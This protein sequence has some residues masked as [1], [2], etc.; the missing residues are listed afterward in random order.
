MIEVPSIM[1]IIDHLKDHCSFISVG[2]NDLIQYILAVD[3]LNEKVAFMY[4]PGHPAVLRTLDHIIQSCHQHGLEINV[5]GEMAGDILYAPLL[6]GMGVHNL[7]LNPG[8]Y[9]EIKYLMRSVT[10]VELKALVRE[11][12]ENKS[13]VDTAKK[14]KKFY[15]EKLHSIL[16]KKKVR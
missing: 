10:S 3:R 11:V 12:L 16:A 4:N 9:T 15:F 13:S 6:L 8:A 14:L 5:C 2:T 7:S 1:M